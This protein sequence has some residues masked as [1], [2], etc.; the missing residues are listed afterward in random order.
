MVPR[1][2]HRYTDRAIGFR[3]D[4]LVAEP[5]WAAAARQGL[6][7]VAYQATLAYQFLPVNTAP[8]AK[9]PPVVVNGY[10]TKTVAPAALVRAANGTTEEC[11]AWKPAI[12]ATHCFSWTDGPFRLHGAVTSGAMLVSSDPAGP[13]VTVNAAVEETEAPRNRALTRHFSDGLFVAPELV[14]HFRL[15]S[16]SA[17]GHAHPRARFLQRHAPRRRGTAGDVPSGLTR[18]DGR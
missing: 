15:F 6:T 9:A 7:A 17:D 5:I 3:A 8:R 12:H 11:T 2:R 10:Q 16:L 4:S 14:V 13:R 1:A 18:Q